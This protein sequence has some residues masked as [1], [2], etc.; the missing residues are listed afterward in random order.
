VWVTAIALGEETREAFEE[1]GIPREDRR[2]ARSYLRR[3]PPLA[4]VFLCPLCPIAP[5]CPFTP[6]APWLRLSLG[7]S[8]ARARSHL[9]RNLVG[10]VLLGLGNLLAVVGVCVVLR[11][12][13]ALGSRSRALSILAR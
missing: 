13:P 9:R 3:I 12:R 4:H 10:R 11:L 5:L 6:F 2:G 8:R 7:W 1:K